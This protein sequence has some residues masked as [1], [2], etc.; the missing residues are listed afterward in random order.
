MQ[1]DRQPCR[2]VF[3]RA[4]QAIDGHSPYITLYPLLVQHGLYRIGE[5]SK[6]K[7]PVVFWRCLHGKAS[8][9]FSGPFV[10]SAGRRTRHQRFSGLLSQPS[11]TCSGASLPSVAG[12]ALW[13][14]LPDD[15]GTIERQKRFSISCLPYCCSD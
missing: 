3:N 10:R 7:L 1:R 11:S 2:T 14:V 8:A 12:S 4:I 15:V 9:T 5:L 13:N 6:C